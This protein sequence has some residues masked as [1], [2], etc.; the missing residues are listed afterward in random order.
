MLHAVTTYFNPNKYKARYEN[1]QVFRQ[2]LSVPLLVVELDMGSGFELGPQDA[3]VLIQLSGSLLWQKERLLNSALVH[4]P[5]E[6]TSVAWLDCDVLFSQADWATQA[7]TLL[8]KYPV[9]QL[10]RELVHLPQGKLPEDPMVVPDSA[11]RSSF[12]H[13]WNRGVLPKD[14]FLDASLSGKLRCNC[15]MAWAARR[16]LLE[17]HGLCDTFILGMGDKQFAAALVGLATDAADSLELSRQHRN[18]YLQWAEALH[19]DVRGQ[20][21]ALPQTLFHLWHGDLKDRRYDHRYSG[22][23]RFQFDPAQ[24]LRAC[25]QGAWH[26]STELPDLQAHISSY[27]Q[28]RRED[29]VPV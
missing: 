8:S 3:D 19:R 6:C 7:Q 17:R 15:G 4:L 1:Y 14:F 12:A 21:G 27:F 11:R 29:G 2:N 20:V 18:H 9:L 16:D 13:S 10:F 23:R 26:W 25:K 22:F 5:P 28:S 24:H